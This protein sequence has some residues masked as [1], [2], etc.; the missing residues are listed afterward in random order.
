[1]IRQGDGAPLVEHSRPLNDYTT[2]VHVYQGCA[3]SRSRRCRGAVQP[4]ARR[5]SATTP[6]RRSHDKGLI[7]GARRGAGGR[8]AADPQRL[9]HPAGAEPGA[10][11][12]LVA[13]RAAGGR[14]DLR[15]RL[16]PRERDR[17]SLRLQLRRDRRQRRPRPADPASAGA[18]AGGG[19]GGA[20]RHRER[21]PADRRRQ[22]DQQPLGRRPARGPGLDLALQR[23]CRIRTSTARSACARWRRR[24]PGSRRA[25]A[26]AARGEL[27][28]GSCEGVEQIRASGDLGGTAGGHRDRTRGRASCRRTTPRAPTSGSTSWSR[29]TASGLRYYEVTNAQHLDAFN[30]FAGFDS[31]FVPLHHYFIQALDLM[32]DHLKNGTP[33]PPSQVIHTDAARHDRCRNGACRW[34]RTNIPPILGGFR[35]RAT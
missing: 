31:R 24:G 9:R 8:R 30:A 27:R 2:L 17:R 15:Q 13:C 4:D 35:T 16:Q 10:A 32:Y 20:V 3:N 26:G 18:A 25:A 11:V 6:A 7:A 21:H 14:G 1:M 12:A 34:T 5:A 22:P 23:R 19:R 33:L 28:T 29:A